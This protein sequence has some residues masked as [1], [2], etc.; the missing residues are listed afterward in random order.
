MN[1]ARVSSYPQE[2]RNYSHKKA[3][4]MIIIWMGYIWG[5]EYKCK[6]TTRVWNYK[7]INRSVMEMMLVMMMVME[8]DVKAFKILVPSP[9]CAVVMLE[10]FTEVVAMKSPRWQGSAVRVVYDGWLLPW[11]LPPLYRPRGCPTTPYAFLI[12]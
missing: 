12:T 4:N 3:I 7:Q 11:L 8:I 1:N 2:Q 5:I 9:P 10:I 6:S